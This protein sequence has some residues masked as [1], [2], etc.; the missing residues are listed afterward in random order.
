ML[1]EINQTEKGNH[2]MVKFI[3]GIQEIVKWTIRERRE[4]EWRK[5]REEDKP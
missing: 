3:C 2:H 1:S 5:I 4:T